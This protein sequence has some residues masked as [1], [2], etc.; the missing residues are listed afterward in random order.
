MFVHSLPIDLGREDFFLVDGGFGDDDPVRSA[1][2][3]LAPELDAIAAGRRF[4]SDAIR[5]RDVAAVRDGV[6]ALDRFPRRMLRFAEFFLL[7]W[8]TADGGRVKKNLGP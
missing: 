6:C 1:D 4:V 8:V 2:E 3:T 7:F 5:H